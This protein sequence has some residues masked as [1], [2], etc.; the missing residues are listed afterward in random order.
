MER[1]LCEEYQGLGYILKILF[2]QL[3]MK[4][5]VLVWGASNL[6]ELEFEL[7]YC[8]MDATKHEIFLVKSL[9]ASAMSINLGKLIFQE[10]NGH[11]STAELT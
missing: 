5:Y 8:K 11:K 6:M 4:G 3:S 9:R 7:I 2:K 10:D 1:F